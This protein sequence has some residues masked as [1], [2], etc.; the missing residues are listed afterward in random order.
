MRRL[1]LAL[2]LVLA[3]A[4]VAAAQPPTAQQQL[5]QK[6][7]RIKKRIRAM[8]AYTL[9]DELAL[10]EATAGKLFPLLAR[11]DDEFDKLLG[12]RAELHQHLVAA[13]NGNDPRATNKV[14]DAAIANQRAFWN[15][16]DKRIAELRN[17]LTP[18]QTARL[19]VVLPRFERRIENQ[20]RNA[21][22]GKGP[23]TPARQALDDDG[24]DAPRPRQSPP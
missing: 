13:S 7:E 8:R 14:I 3:G 11:Y 22:Q 1:A 21:I 5:Q 16:E 17:I 12:A 23:G 15:L 9:T 18:A 20:L 2:V 6:R 19:L 10:D 4:T 24:D